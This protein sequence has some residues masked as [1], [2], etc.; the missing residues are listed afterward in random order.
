MQQVEIR[1]KGRVNGR[2]SDWL[3]GM[4]M[5]HTTSGNTV[6]TGDVRD[7]AAL[8]GMINRIADLGIE[9]ISVATAPRVE[10]QLTARQKEAAT[11][12]TDTPEREN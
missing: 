5:S 8:R 7:Q 12:T 4:S 9:L 10:G 3:G 2:W 1:V 6:L 11:A